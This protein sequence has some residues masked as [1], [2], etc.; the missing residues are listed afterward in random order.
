MQ[1]PR[2][3]IVPHNPGTPW[4]QEQ[5]T[6]VSAGFKENG[7]KPSPTPLTLCQLVKQISG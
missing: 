7:S 2:L 6:A 5:T 3:L 1:K 4:A